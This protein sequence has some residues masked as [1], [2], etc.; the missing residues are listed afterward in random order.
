MAPSRVPAYSYDVW[1]AGWVGQWAQLPV[2]ALLLTAK[3]STLFL[4]P[5]SCCLVVYQHLPASPCVSVLRSFPPSVSQT[6]SLFLGALPS[7]Y[8]FP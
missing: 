2:T 3:A 8:L 4:S 5:S 7:A 6:F 1:R